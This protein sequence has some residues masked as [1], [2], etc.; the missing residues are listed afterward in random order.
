LL[1]AVQVAFESR[2]E[3]ELLTL[4]FDA[5]SG[6]KITSRRAD[7]YFRQL[8]QFGLV[9]SIYSPAPVEYYV[10]AC[11]QKLGLVNM[12]SLRS[13]V[14]FEKIFRDCPVEGHPQVAEIRNKALTADPDGYFVWLTIDT[15][16]VV[17]PA[18]QSP[19]DLAPVYLH[20][21]FEGASELVC[22]ASGATSEFLTL[23][24]VIDC[25]GSSL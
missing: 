22:V 13:G 19:F 3:S 11:E 20:Q 14:E 5:N 16:S 24:T 15:S 17:Y 12:A 10:K 25:L 21:S 1:G 6:C 23:P 18:E 4:K 7:S 8:S 9:V 2:D